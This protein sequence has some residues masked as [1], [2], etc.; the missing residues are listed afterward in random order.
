MYDYRRGGSVFGAFLLGGL[1]GAILGLL[2]A[3]RSG[4][5]TREIIA[6]KAED[7]WGQGVEVYNTGKDK[8]VEAYSTGKDKVGESAEQL[9]VKIDEARGRL[10]ETVSKSAEGAKGKLDDAVPVAKDAVDKAAEKTK[11]GIDVAGSKASDTLGAVAE[12]AKTVKTSSRHRRGCRARG[13]GPRFAGTIEAGPA[14]RGRPS[15]RVKGGVR[16]LASRRVPARRLLGQGQT[17]WP[18]RR[19]ALR[20][21]GDLRRR[22][23]R[24]AASAAVSDRSQRPLPGARSRA[25]REG[26]PGGG[27]RERRLGWLGGQAAGAL[28]GRHRHL[29]GD[30]GVNR[31]RREAGV[32]TRRAV[33]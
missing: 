24:V 4:K 11:S 9:K 27:R 10:Q 21:R 2:F 31:E 20:P 1:I 13:V 26:R 32:R 17:H 30:A 7:Y 5:E 12:K 28:L 19:R 18:G 22:L 23:R 33:R 3:P 15:C 8:A 16:A 6:D 14:P 29:G 25:L